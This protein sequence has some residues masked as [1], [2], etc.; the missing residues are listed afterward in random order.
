MSELPPAAP[1][2]WPPMPPATPESPEPASTTAWWKPRRSW[3]WWTVTGV[4]ALIVLIIIAAIAAPPKKPAVAAT[5][6]NATD[7]GQAT[8]EPTLD[9]PT[10][11]GSTANASTPPPTA[12]P[13]AVPTAPPTA[14]ST[15]APVTGLTKSGR[16]DSV[17]TVP[18]PYNNEPTLVKVKYTGSENFALTTLGSDNGEEELLVDAIGS[19][20]GVEAMDFDGTN[21]AVRLEVTASGSWTVTFS[22]PSTAPR[23]GTVSRGRGDAVIAYSGSAN[24]AAFTSTGGGNF[25]VLQFNSPGSLENLLVDTIGA[26]TGSVPVDSSGFLVITDDGNWSVTLSSS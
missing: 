11:D 4:A 10:P 7:S 1:P 12:A 2:P 25:A 26:Y 24:T 5:A 8:P 14:P 9:I 20:S 6:P 21:P 3:K 23:F 22:D 18:A 15:A 13:T 17:I 16:G 19:Y